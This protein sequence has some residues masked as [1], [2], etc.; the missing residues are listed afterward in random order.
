MKSLGL[1]L[2]ISL[3]VTSAALAESVYSGSLVGGPRYNISEKEGITS[4]MLL[5]S[6]AAEERREERTEIKKGETRSFEEL[7][8]L[9]K[10]I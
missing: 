4:Q 10:R 2:A 9:E 3:A 5:R 6:E 8:R 1:L 7:L